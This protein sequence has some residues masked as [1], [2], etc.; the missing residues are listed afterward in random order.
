MLRN[1]RMTPMKIF[2]FPNN[3]DYLI[4]YSY[5]DGPGAWALS[6]HAAFVIST[7]IINSVYL[8]KIK[9]NLSE[10]NLKNAK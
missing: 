8:A 5:F 6:A 2:R 9:R 3:S 1:F 7:L 10:K 4:F